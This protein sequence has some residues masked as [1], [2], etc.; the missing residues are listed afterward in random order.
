ML[1][2]VTSEPGPPVP[3]ARPAPKPPP[4]LW[5]FAGPVVMLVLAVGVGI[6][7]FVGTLRSVTEVYAEVPA[8]GEPHL[9]SVD[10]DDRVTL[11][12]PVGT[13]AQCR[14]TDTAGAELPVEDHSGSF[15]I[16][17][18]GREW[19]AAGWFDPRVADEVAVACP[20]TP[21]IESFLVA[22]YVRIGG[23]VVRILA[24]VLVP[25]V[26]GGAGALW[27]VVLA[28]LQVVRRSE[29]GRRV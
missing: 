29:A 8:D 18:R 20:R 15:T 22:P 6:A 26:V 25:L 10:P 23:F 5:W 2:P 1:A 24:T 14:V 21:G 3:P 4:S 28:V 27:L 7:F 11:L 17:T 13:L 16:T 19:E 12:L 9:V